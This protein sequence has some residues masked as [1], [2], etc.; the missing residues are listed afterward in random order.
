MNKR[1]LYL[2]PSSGI[3]LEQS[4]GAGTHIRGAIQ[5]FKENGL[6]VL[7][8]IGGNV[9][10]T[11]QQPSIAANSG[12]RSK[13]LFRQFVKHII[14]RRIRLLVRDIRTLWQDRK[15][16]KLTLARI[17]AFKPDFIY[18][19]ASYL[20][21]Y[22]MRIAKRLRIPYFIETD[23]CMVEII[24]KDYGV[25]SESIGNRIEKTKMHRSDRVVVMNRLAIDFVSKK[26]DLPTD[27]FVVKTLG[28]N[29]EE[30]GFD[31]GQIRILKDR[32]NLHNKFVIGFVGAISTYHG[33]NYL[34]DAAN[35][36]HEKKSEIVIM[37]VGWSREGESL[38]KRAEESGLTNVIFTG[39]VDKSEV[40]N[41][42]KLFDVGVIPDCEE[43]I[44]PI[45]VLEYGLMELSPLV[46]EYRVFNEIIIPGETGYYFHPKDS[47]SLANSILRLSNEREKVKAYARN[48]SNF[49]KENFKWKNAVRDIIKVLNEDTAITRAN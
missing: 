2:A 40:A 35:H 23:G 47:V 36:I 5:G 38:K 18:E 10:N 34:I 31:N 42:Y 7:P 9:L 46:P 24:S 33:V 37:V 29:D 6:E 4:G 45:K 49:V 26:F 20:S 28:V 12:G 30:F 8:I 22:G 17:V 39:K 25:F 27:K 3:V 48:W 1:L 14:P 11:A 43:S 21:T 32:Y 19:R 44:Y 13:K 41:Y 15:L 16:E